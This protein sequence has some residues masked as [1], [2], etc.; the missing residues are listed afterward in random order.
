VGKAVGAMARGVCA[1]APGRVRGGE[2]TVKDDLAPV[3]DLAVHPASHPLPDERSEQAGRRALALAAG[4]G[5]ADALVVVVS[6]GAS[7]LWAVPAPGLTLDEKRQT[8]RA[9]ARTGCDVRA[10]NVVRRHLSAIKGGRLAAATRAGTVV[11]LLLSDVLGDPVHA[12][13]SGP[14]VADPS[15]LEQ[16]RRLVAATP[17]VPASV[18]DWLAA[19][20]AETPKVLPERGPVALVGNHETLRGAALAAAGA[21][22]LEAILL[23]ATEAEVRSCAEALAALPPPPAG[24]VYVGGGEPTVTVCGT[25]SG[26]RAQHLALEMARRLRGTERVFLS[27]GSDGSDGP[28]S[29][30]GAVVDGQSWDE[31][32]RRGLDPTSA[33]ADFDSARVHAMLGTAIVTG[34]TGTNLLDLHL[35]G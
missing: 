9:L 23:P 19:E 7:A 2:I 31:A 1:S 35:L 10:L 30:A 33:L 16:A 24:S 12:I 26:G 8:V 15:T 11:T 14:T 29:A 21:A 4:L 32:L 22:G 5:P 3:A 25:G 17:G 6:G 27:A 18:L 28:T 13:G 20:A 34:P